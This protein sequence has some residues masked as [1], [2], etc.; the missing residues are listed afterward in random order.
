MAKQLSP[1]GL[2]E[3]SII[4][5][6]RKGIWTKFLQAVKRYKLIE[7]GDKIAVCI[8]GGKDSVLLAKCVQELKKHSEIQ[9]DA[10]YIVMNPGYSAENLERIESNLRLLEIPARIFDSD[11]FDVNELI[12]GE[13]PCYLCA[14]MRRGFLY[15]RAQELGCNKIALGHHMSDVIETT[16]MSMFF[17]GQIQGMMPK[18]NS[19]HFGGMQLI[20]PLYCVLDDEIIRWKDYNNLQFIAC[21]CKLTENLSVGEQGQ[22]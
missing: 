5:K 14:R 6:F 19:T 22:S 20:R 10:E 16:L 15:A 21:A 2:V 11:I 1:C 17:G 9:F 18:I 3:R 12:G 13:H 7:E 4:T 8:S